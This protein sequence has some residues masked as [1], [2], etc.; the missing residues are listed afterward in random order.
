MYKLD[1][2]HV[3]SDSKKTRSRMFV[4]NITRTVNNKNRFINGRIQSG[5]FRVGDEIMVFPSKI[6]S[7]I[8]SIIKN[9]DR[10]DIVFSPMSVSI[11]VE[12]E[13]DIGRGN[14]ITKLNSLPRSSNEVEVILCWME[15]SVL[16][17]NNLFT[18]I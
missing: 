15:N 17:T 16:N 11:E 4:Q 12:D 7:K 10:T 9:F 5:I 3:G 14:L 18:G 2:T 8:K 13:I 6:K 1:N